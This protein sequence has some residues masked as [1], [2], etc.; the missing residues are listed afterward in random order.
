[1]TR[2]AHAAPA[3]TEAQL[4]GGLRPGEAYDVRLERAGGFIEV[5]IASGSEQK[6]DEAGVIVLGKQAEP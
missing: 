5:T 1:M 2:G 6:A 4:A 3:K